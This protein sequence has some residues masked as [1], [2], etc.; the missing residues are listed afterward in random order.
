MSGFSELNV[1]EKLKQYA[2]IFD[3]YAFIRETRQKQLR[4]EVI[5]DKAFRDAKCDSDILRFM[6]KMRESNRQN[7]M[8][9]D[10]VNIIDS[11]PLMKKHLE[12]HQVV[13]DNLIKAATTGTICECVRSYV[14]K[15][16]YPK[17]LIN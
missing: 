4:E 10:N 5:I 7:A 16:K 17:I 6:L 1:W 8:I 15:H 13:Q 3:D 14:G 9:Y 2:N 11:V 12:E